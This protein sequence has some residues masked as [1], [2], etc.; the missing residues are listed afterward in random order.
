MRVGDR[1]RVTS[2]HVD[3]TVPQHERLH[4]VAG[5]E[6]ADAWKVDQRGR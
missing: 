6:V 4:V 5:H 2:A 1:V 3:P